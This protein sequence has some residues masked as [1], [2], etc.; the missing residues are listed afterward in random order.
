MLVI[1]NN[2]EDIIATILSY[3]HPDLKLPPWNL[4]VKYLRS[5]PPKTKDYNYN[6]SLSRTWKNEIMGNSKDT[7]L[8]FFVS[9][10][11]LRKYGYDSIGY[12]NIVKDDKII[13]CKFITNKD[14]GSGGNGLVFF[15]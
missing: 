10:D 3:A 1:Q 11:T 8:I 12:A 2:S 5:V 13:G 9:Q 4:A 6:L 7:L 14:L 15:S